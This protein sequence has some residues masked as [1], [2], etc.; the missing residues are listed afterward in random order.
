MPQFSDFTFPSCNG[1]TNI[2]VRRCTPDGEVRAVMQIAH[3]IAEHVE[4]YDEFAAFLA[5]NGI[6]VYANDHLGHGESLAQP[7]DLG[8]FAENGGWALVVGDMRRLHDIIKREYPDKPCFIFGH[9]MGSFLTRTYLIRYPDG[10]DG[11][12]ICGTGHQASAVVAS[13]RALCRLEIERHGARH[14]SKRLNDVAFGAYNRGF[15]PL[16]T[17][18]DW[19]TRDEKTVDAY[20]ADEKCGFI[21][22]AGLFRDM[23]EGI[24]F[25]ESERN[26]KRMDKD[27]PVLFISG[28]EDP[29]GEHGR[30]VMRAYSAFVKSG[31]R[32]C[33]LKLY[34]GGRHEILNETNRDEVYRDVLNW[35]NAKARA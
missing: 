17:T 30:G 3:G 21:P 20:L 19:L 31:V 14:P 6:A 1:K 16:R 9:S 10:L 27:L 23:M 7:E 24:A 15:E 5:E 35:L 28:A 25:I 33:T 26:I 22:T 32:D 12:V 34:T 29:V 8:F 2:H 4:R 11:A 13:G 18:H